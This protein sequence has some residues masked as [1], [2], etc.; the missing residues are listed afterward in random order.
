MEN[1]ELIAKAVDYAKQNG[2]FTSTDLGF[3]VVN[4]KYS[5]KNRL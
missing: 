3:E 4:W 2:N 5:L 1:K